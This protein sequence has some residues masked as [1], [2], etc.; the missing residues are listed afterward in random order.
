MKVGVAVGNAVGMAV[1]YPVGAN[2]G[3]NVGDADG[4]IVGLLVLLS[5]DGS[6]VGTSEGS[7]VTVE[8]PGAAPARETA[9]AKQAKAEPSDRVG[10]AH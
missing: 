10:F 6:R 4:T 9:C 1:G 8:P 2:V 7:A 3:V 5:N